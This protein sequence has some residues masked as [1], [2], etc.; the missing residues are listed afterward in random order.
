[1]RGIVKGFTIETCE[2]DIVKLTLRRLKILRGQ[3]HGLTS[4]YAGVNRILN[5]NVVKVY[6]KN[7]TYYKFYY[8]YKYKFTFKIKAPLGGFFA[9]SL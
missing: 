8:K 5:Y 2:G 3:L 1:M 6:Y 4:C 7:L 9:I